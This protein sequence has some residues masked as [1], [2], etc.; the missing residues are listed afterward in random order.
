MDATLVRCPSCRN[1]ISA[2]ADSCPRCG[3]TERAAV[4]TGASD[5]SGPTSPPP[6]VRPWRP[7]RDFVIACVTV[8]AGIGLL[9]IVAIMIQQLLY[10]P[11]ASIRS[12]FGALDDRDPAAVAGVIVEDHPYAG[13]AIGK[14][15]YQPP[16]GFDIGRVSGDDDAR[17]AEVS[18][19]IGGQDFSSTVE[20]ERD[21]EDRVLGVFDRWKIVNPVGGLTFSGPYVAPVSVN[22]QAIP[23][24]GTD[25]MP[26]LYP[27]SYRVTVADN[28]IA[29]VEPIDAAVQ[30]SSETRAELTAE[31]KPSANSD[32]EPKIKAHVDGCIQAAQKGDYQQL[33]Q[34][35]FLEEVD[36]YGGELS[37]T[38]Y[39]VTEVTIGE[40]QIQVG[41]TS[42]GTVLIKSEYGDDETASIT[43]TGYAHVDQSGEI[44]FTPTQ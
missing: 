4:T 34:C 12:Y 36:L 35:T 5:E 28:P 9:I 8:A 15:G 19:Q 22:G 44:A 1:V 2:A 3:S 29:T 20:L 33:D 24:R 30:L 7:T 40:G 13:E 16:S 21:P 38:S 26:V 41:T 6:F 14:D 43:I 18:Y 23:V 39:P 10:S 27:G 11:Q 37:V 32:L 42:P 31:L 17:T 25:T